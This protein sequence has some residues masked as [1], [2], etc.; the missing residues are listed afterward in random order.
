MMVGDDRRYQALVELGVAPRGDAVIAPFVAEW[1]GLVP[2]S[3]D[4]RPD[5]FLVKPIVMHLSEVPV[6]LVSLFVTL[7]ALVGSVFYVRRV[8]VEAELRRT[9]LLHN[10]HLRQ[11]AQLT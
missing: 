7:A 3:Y 11:M 6:R 5:G 9:W 2:R 1:A 10:W 8:V 4:F